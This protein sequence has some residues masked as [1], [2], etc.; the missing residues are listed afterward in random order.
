[1]QA[2]LRIKYVKK[3]ICLTKNTFKFKISPCQWVCAVVNRQFDHCGVIWWMK[4]QLT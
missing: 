1:M 2:R 4:V 3:S